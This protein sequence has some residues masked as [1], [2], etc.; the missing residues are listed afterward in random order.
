VNAG[1][2]MLSVYVGSST[3]ICYN[4]EIYFVFS[5]HYLVIMCCR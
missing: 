5:I 1:S 4:V 2:A 3:Q